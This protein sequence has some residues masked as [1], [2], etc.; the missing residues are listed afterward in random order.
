MFFASDTFID[1]VAVFCKSP[2][3][4][5]IKLTGYFQPTSTVTPKKGKFSQL[6]NQIFF[7]SVFEEPVIQEFRGT[8]TGKQLDIE[9]AVDLGANSFKCWLD[10]LSK[11]APLP[12]P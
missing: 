4:V 12:P 8:P 11:S 2:S 3:P 1:A 5:H 7:M 6:Q 9:A 10:I